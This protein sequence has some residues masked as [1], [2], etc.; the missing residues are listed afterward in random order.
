M[1]TPLSACQP[2][3]RRTLQGLVRHAIVETRFRLKRVDD[4]QERFD[5]VVNSLPKKSFR[6][7][8][9]L[10]TDPTEDDPNEQ[11]KE[12]LCVFHH[13]TVF[14]RVERRHQMDALGG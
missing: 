14:Q 8:L 3:G 1:E 2:S 5:Q 7:V 4:K 11:L 12:R 9:N 10:I 6:T 13:L